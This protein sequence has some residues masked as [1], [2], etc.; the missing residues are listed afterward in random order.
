MS[1]YPVRFHEISLNSSSIH[2]EEVLDAFRI[3]AVAL[4]TDAFHFFDLPCLTRTLDV[5]EVYL[6]VLAEVDDGPQEVEEPWR[7]TNGNDTEIYILFAK[8]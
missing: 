2:L 5:F 6:G 7:Q 3:V 1:D 4:P 8:W